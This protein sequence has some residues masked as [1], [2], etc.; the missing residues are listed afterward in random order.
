MRKLGLTLIAFFMLL[1]CAASGQQQG[2]TKKTDLQFKAGSYTAS[3]QGYNGEVTIEATFSEN[4]ITDIQIQEQ[5]ETAHVGDSAY[6]ILIED[7]IAA[8][9]TG[10]D[11]VSGATFT[12][13][14]LKNA[15]NAAAEAAEASDLDTFKNN[16]VT[17]QAKDEIT[18]TWDVVIVGAGGAGTVRK[19]GQNRI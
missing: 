10:V 4:A 5:K 6:P 16:T 13:I 9:G 17:H 15:V 14:A 12:S 7:I 19:S 8:N 1:S 2:E 18:G 3:A 11:G